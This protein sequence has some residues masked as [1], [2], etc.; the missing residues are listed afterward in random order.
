MPIPPLD[1]LAHGPIV[2]KQGNLST[3]ALRFLQ[4]L[5]QQPATNTR[6]ISAAYTADPL[7]TD[8]YVSAGTFTLTFPV[9][10]QLAGKVWYVF[11]KGAGTVTFAASGGSVLGAASIGANAGATVKCDGTDILIF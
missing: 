2:D 6:S 9:S 4:Q 11:N 8:L 7:D 3:A 5:T 10:Q 1:S